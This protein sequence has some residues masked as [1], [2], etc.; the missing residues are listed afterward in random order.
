MFI[1]RDNINISL[2]FLRKNKHLFYCI[3]AKNV[4]KYIKGIWFEETGVA[5]YDL[6]KDCPKNKVF[7]MEQIVRF[8]SNLYRNG[9]D[10]DD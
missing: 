3:F 1:S 8:A 2:V 6:I 4:V 7:D 5:F 9:R 10:K